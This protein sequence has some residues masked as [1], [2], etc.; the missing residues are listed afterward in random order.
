MVLPIGYS[1]GSQE[2]FSKLCCISSGSS[3]FAK[4]PVSVF[5]VYKGSMQWLR[6]Y[7]CCTYSDQTSYC[8]VLYFP[9]EIFS[10]Q[11]DVFIITRAI[12]TDA[13]L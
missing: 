9:R 7:L 10:F 2:E 13:R 8:I 5:P 12:T 6:L 4:V 3:L 11:M 1:N